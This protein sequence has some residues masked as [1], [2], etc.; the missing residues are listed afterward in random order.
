MTAYRDTH[1]KLQQEKAR[2]DR[3]H[4]NSN[5]TRRAWLAALTDAELEQHDDKARDISDLD[6]E[7]QAMIN[8]TIALIEDEKDHRRWLRSRPDGCICPDENLIDPDCSHTRLADGE[9][10]NITHK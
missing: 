10:E 9:A 8:N 1:Q 5:D 7:T 4:M 6:P 2:Y 3:S